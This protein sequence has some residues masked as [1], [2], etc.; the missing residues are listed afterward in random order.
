MEWHSK[1]W[2]H[3]SSWLIFSDISCI[4]EAPFQP[5]ADLENE[6]TSDKKHFCVFVWNTYMSSLGS[7][8][9]SSFISI[10]RS[11]NL[12]I[13]GSSKNSLISQLYRVAG[14]SSANDLKLSAEV[15]MPLINTIVT[16][17]MNGTYPK[18]SFL[19][20]DVPT[21]AAHHKVNIQWWFEV[22]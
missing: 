21:D 18:G 20:V 17:I 16:E 9:N 14:Q 7:W 15:C 6:L 12:N 13:Y 19:N 5:M 22:N 1:V 3:R 4:I 2:N 8:A 11:G 10:L